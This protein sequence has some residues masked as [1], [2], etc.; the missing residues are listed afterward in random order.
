MHA[1]NRSVRPAV[2]AMLAFG[3]LG[4]MAAQDNGSSLSPVEGLDNWK[5][6]LDLAPYAPGKYNLIVEARDK[7]GNVTRARPMNIYVD[8][9]SDL[10]LVSII[11]P[12]S[13]MRVGGDLNI[14]GTAIDDDGVDHVEVSLDGGEYVRAEGGEFWS[15][16][17]K[18]ADIPEGRRTLDVRAVDINALAGPAVRVR[19]DL[20]RTKPLATVTTP[21]MGSLVSGTIRLSGDVFDANGVRSLEISQDGITTWTKVDLKK[22]KDP[23]RPAFSWAVD[24]R[25]LADGP[26][27]F[28]L[29]SVDMVGSTSIAAYLLFIDNTKPSV[30]IAMPAGGRVVNG[31]FSVAGAV[32]D[33][34]GVK[35]LSYE[36]N[37]GEKGEI[38]LTKGDPFFVK[39][40]DAG[41]VR[42]DSAVLTLVAEDTIGNVTR[43][44][45]T[46]KIDR[47]ADKPV[48]KVLG[49][50]AGT[51][52]GT[53]AKASAALPVLRE[54]D[55][56]WGSVADD[57][58]VVGFRWSVDGSPPVQV[59]CSDVFSLVLPPLATGKH[60]LSLV[61]IDIHSLAGD[62]TIFPFILDKGPGTIHFDR[63]GGAKAMRDFAQGASTSVDA[64]EF[65]EG[66]IAAPNPPV[67]AEY[68]V[69]GG[70]ARALVLAKGAD[71]QSWRF[72]IALD[73]ALPYG[74][75]TIALRV[76]DAVGTTY[77]GDA[78]VYVTNLAV[79]R[80]ET[81][82]RFSDPR[83]GVDGRVLFGAAGVD[84]RVK[85]LLGAFYGG[86]LSALRLDPPCDLVVASFDGRSVSLAVAKPGLSEATRLVGT[87][88]KG[89]EFS[90]G[91]FVFDT[92]STP[93][94]LAIDGPAQGTWFK[95]AILVTGKAVDAGGA[96]TLSWRTLPDGEAV[97][98][99]LSPEGGFSI[100]LSAAELP[101]GP[102]SIELEARDPAGNAARGYL[103]LGA[104][105][106]APVPRFLS[107]EP[108]ATVWGS[109][110]VAAAIDDVSGLA[111]VEYAADGASFA[112]IEWKGS[113]FVHRA[114][115]AA[116][117]KA[118]YRI[119]DR[120]G[121]A[122]F[123][124][125]DLVIGPP[126]PRLP[127]A[128]SL[129]VEAQAGEAR[130]ELKGSS[131][132]SK[133]SILLPA[134]LQSG[135]EALG[136]QNSPPP[137]RFET[138]LLLSGA[139]S[140]AGQATVEGQVK[141][142]SLSMDGGESYRLLASNKDA[143]TARSSLSFSLAVEAAKLAPGAA[144]W[145]IRVEDFSEPPLSYFCPL[146]CLVDMKPP[147]LAVLFPD[148]STLSMPGPFPL[149]FKAEDENGLASGDITLA[150]AA[151]KEALAVEAGGRY[152]ARMVDPSQPAL[153]GGPLA[154]SLLVKDV[155]GN[156]AGLALK[157]GY[158]AAADAPK[159]RLDSPALDAKGLVPPLNALA[160]LSGLASDDDGFPPV[161]VTIDAGQPL[162]FPSGAFALALPDLPPGK[163][164]LA[165]EAGEA[166][167][168]LLRLVKDFVLRGPGPAL[169]D[170]AIGGAKA[171]QPWSP[172]AD[173]A[174]ES[175]S[176]VMGTVLAANPL[177]SLRVA[178][179]GGPAV[180]ATLGKAG[181][182]SI[183]FSTPLPP[184]LPYDRVSI[185][186]VA[187]D[188]IGLTG[189]A[190]LELHRILKP[191]SGSDDAEGLRFADARIIV[192]EGTS[193]F[194]LAPGDKLVGRFNSRPI[195]SLALDPPNPALKTAFDGASVS[196]EGAAE[197]LVGSSVLALTTVDGDR[198][199]W[200]PFTA[201]VDAGPPALEIA[202]PSDNDWTRGEVRVAGTSADPQG[203]A[204]VQVSIDGGEAISLAGP[205]FDRIV[206]L[207]SVPEGA[208][209]LDFLARDAAG[210]ETRVTRFIN[211]DS[212]PP[213]LSQVEP[214]VGESVNGLTSFVGEAVDGGRLASVVFLAAAGAPS[215]EV[216]GLAAFS[217]DLDLAR[218]DL[219]LREGGG[220]LV[221]DRA[222]NQ[223]LFAPSVVVD[224]EK[225][226]PVVEIHAPLDEEVLRGDFA[227]SGIAYDDDGLAAAFYRLDGGEW[228]RL[229]MQGT[230]FSVP[231]MLKD[232]GDN[233][234]LVE[235][236]AEDIYGVQGDIV[237]RKYRISREEPVA[238]MTG[239]PI[240]KPLRGSIQLL[241]TASD[242][243]GI[244]DVSVSVDNR[245]SYDA[246]VGTEAWSLG[247]DTT[248][249]SDGI[250][251]VAVRPIDG[252]QTEGFYASM[253]SIDNT[254]PKAMLDLPRDGDEVAGS[255]AVSG[256]VSDN[257][258]IASSRMEIAPVGAATPPRLVLELGT[259]TIVQ[260]VLDLA[261]LA[262][263]A[264]TV[265]LIV[266]DRAD[267]EA[268]A[269]RDITVLGGLPVDSVSIV[270]PV[271]GEKPAGHMRVQG[272]ARMAS[273]SGPVSLLVDDTLLGSADPDALG[274]YSL[275]IPTESLPD[276]SH[277]LK[278]RTISADG[279]M[280]E[281]PET[282]VEWSS[283]GPWITIDSIPSGTYLSN[284]PY[285]RGRAGWAAEATPD[286]DKKASA[287]YAKA[288]KARLPASVELSLDDGRSFLPAK[289][290]AAWSYRLE[291]QDYRE[292][293]LHVI[294]RA[295]YAN[296]ASSSVKS[297]YFLDKTPPDVEVLSPA[298]GG[299]FNGVLALSG[300]AADLN[301][302]ESVGVALR[303]GDK[304]R[305]EVPSFIQGLY[306]DGQALG[307][308]TWQAGLG[309]TFF[310]DNVKLQ[311]NFG[312]LKTSDQSFFGDV[313]GAKII[314]N[315]LFLPFDSFLGPDWSFLSTSLG[316]G[317]EFSY[318]S[319]TQIAGTGLTIG[320]I[321]A[322][323][324]FPKITLGNS[325]VFKKFSL[326]T[327]GQL[328]VFSSVVEGGFIPK[329]SLG[330][331]I[332]VF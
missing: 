103:S 64:G 23:L 49:P 99:L 253:L 292:G 83:I 267:N 102:F 252:Y 87:T 150:P 123:A 92:D 43:F 247:L 117:P 9:K 328:W 186:I 112:A 262:P 151:S 181:G 199:T 132:P 101:P 152:F 201:A 166:G 76:K 54:G 47:K 50:A 17:L 270:F 200:G 128:T 45:R 272:R 318:F 289:G 203:I 291:T 42:G 109:E 234:H 75:A 278:A 121:N 137:P 56:L 192:S 55:A 327:E 309:L 298:E 131:G 208:T 114:D 125:P 300:R 283:L 284:R 296:G 82:F 205:A 84:G 48:L 159:I 241:G 178:V 215:Q 179:N 245:A 249:L 108:G 312:Q 21:A 3:F 221:T 46:F 14:V 243:N 305:Y 130:I 143:K 184:S 297:L 120:A 233:E 145:T 276:G 144:R 250:H 182:T 214:A 157:Y 135:Y 153:K 165:I 86:E 274:W 28:S 196:I 189:G 187:T 239:P 197:G 36:F 134:L 176:L 149:V 246:P 155:A 116:N 171:P 257:L 141:T 71:A 94:T 258:A 74:F 52:A 227:I 79:A 44:T 90:A 126:P 280:V 148:R 118:V 158:D 268:L 139:L 168:G 301:G 313:F 204:L 223:A 30:E 59:P 22:G 161:R 255:L 180:Q 81:G 96:A 27:V 282:R 202:S 229:D 225:D 222:G 237:S 88:L 39:E 269:S 273:G 4:G 207:A 198:F 210:R 124:R 236:K 26:R 133:V 213:T 34:V 326:Y 231:C 127:A 72:R 1:W 91:P 70:K 188:S 162:V 251:A 330:A 142:V 183:P 265:R 316:V 160:L 18:T 78:L 209:R 105:A 140:L 31:L 40:F 60:V 321:L 256:R 185:E 104:D 295:R 93:P 68:S 5:Y 224:K 232:T 294:V 259:D 19:F 263:G 271:E 308:T 320:A 177:A 254:P 218:L 244:S 85:S 98:A 154:L 261:A 238:T 106:A 110:D 16:Y 167:S 35:R 51:G 136:D 219:P 67:A 169:G 97:Q 61:P 279:R 324:E 172:G 248:T 260:R 206:S 323:L 275:D 32:R 264:Y 293:G 331:R 311:A 277:R 303:K 129:G 220:F 322:Q 306:L 317:A 193:F 194:L 240:S 310:G 319:E 325:G 164:S 304:S 226:K 15:L 11:N 286:G 281:S 41:K 2:L 57:D 212:L 13:L 29:R 195:A 113:Y 12:T 302:L 80:E 242:A 111:S 288:A 122:T 173:F 66:S 8:P 77:E 191:V 211:K 163:H 107:P 73:A 63:I 266:R 38:P 307:S 89:H 216:S 290:G 174:L 100:E 33:V 119:V 175:G 314:A 285:L 147:T 315:I 332:G 287:A 170:F 7:A 329:L 156:Q 299:R 20:D 230:S 228:T 235:V 146:Y 217:R 25:K 138:R 65:L 69:A 10:P 190:R 115:L 53:A 62:A 58:D 6:G 95:D 24:T 37:S